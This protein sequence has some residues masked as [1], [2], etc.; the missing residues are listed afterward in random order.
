MV[1][2]P[3]QNGDV[4][5]ANADALMADVDDETD[6]KTNGRTV[7]NPPET[8]TNGNG[9]RSVKLEDL[10]ED[11]DSDEEFPSSRRDEVKPS[12]PPVA[13]SSPM[14]GSS[15]LLFRFLYFLNKQ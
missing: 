10:F 12:S 15:R 1:D 9:E 4:P 8:T 5:V 2:S 11:V 3:H 13:P 14:Y 6:T 7:T